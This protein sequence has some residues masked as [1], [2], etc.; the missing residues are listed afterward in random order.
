MGG[1]DAG[2]G[3]LG[4]LSGENRLLFFYFY[5]YLGRTKGGFELVK[6]ERKKTHPCRVEIENLDPWR[7]AAII[8]H[9]IGS[10]KGYRRGGEESCWAQVGYQGF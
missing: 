4:A 1:H 2:G 9:Y 3:K 8:A 10:R 6:T 5:F 7:A